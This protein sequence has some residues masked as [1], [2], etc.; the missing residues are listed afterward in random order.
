MFTS[1]VYITWL[2]LDRDNCRCEKC[3]N[4]DTLQKS[5]DTFSVS[6]YRCPVST[7]FISNE[8]QI[9]SEIKPKSAV[10]EKDGLRV[11]CEL[12]LI[13]M[14][15]SL[16]W[17]FKGIIMDTNPFMNGAGCLPI[18]RVWKWLA[19]IEIA[20]RKDEEWCGFR[21]TGSP[22][23]V[24]YNSNSCTF[25]S[26]KTMQKPPSVHYASIMGSD[27]GVAE[28]T[29]KIVSFCRRPLFR[30][31]LTQ[32]EFGFCYVDGCPISPKKTKKLLER[33]AFI[34]TTHYGGFYDFTSDLTMKDTA[35]TSLALGAH[36]DNTYFTDPAGLQMFHLLSHT[37]GEGGAS[38]LV[39]GFKAAKTLERESITAYR[40]LLMTP[41]TWHASGNEGITI[42]PAKKY[43]VF[44]SGPYFRNAPR[45]LTDSRNSTPSLMQIRWNNDDRG[46]VDMRGA[47]DWY[48][49]ARK[50]DEILKRPESQYWAQLEPGR[51]LIFDN[52]RVLHG[53]SAFTGKRRM[54]GG[55]S[56]F[57]DGSLHV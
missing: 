55:Y 29:N 39:D 37:E 25:W 7:N 51:P 20:L 28:W 54:C 31:N 48:A 15:D 11:T 56:E 45:G 46:P 36:T 17:W 23:C 13:C 44:N 43:P 18:A 9:P 10:I 30:T 50:F 47:E 22:R 1:E 53:R 24:T 42:T 27:L 34:R 4:Q 33:I 6:S 12:A 52:W 3:V 57:F 5:F 14:L 8:S 40:T 32:R 26:E 49:A 2:I 38:L 16:C 21:E 19:W 35:Y 41:V